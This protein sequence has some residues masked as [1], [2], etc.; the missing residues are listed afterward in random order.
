[1][2]MSDG[3]KGD[4]LQ[5]ETRFR[6]D[7]QMATDDLKSY[8]QFETLNVSDAVLACFSCTYLPH[9]DVFNVLDKDHLP[10]R[11][12]LLIHLL[13]LFGSRSGTPSF[14]KYTTLGISPVVTEY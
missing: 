6:L 13:L 3:E 11:P 10:E 1:M 12:L 9:G 5:R 8:R 2:V 14:C 7:L 4:R